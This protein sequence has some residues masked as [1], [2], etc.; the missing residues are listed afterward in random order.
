MHYMLSA[1]WLHLLDGLGH[2]II[3]TGA[4]AQII[5]MTNN[6]MTLGYTYSKLRLKTP[7][8]PKFSAKFYT[9]AD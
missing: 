6:T 1:W 4:I 5:L 2:Y 3:Q 8:P 9:S 7:T